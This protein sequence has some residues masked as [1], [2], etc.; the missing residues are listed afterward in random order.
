MQSRNVQT[1]FITRNKKMT[2]ESNVPVTAAVPKWQRVLIK[3]ELIYRFHHVVEEQSFLIRDCLNC[4]LKAVKIKA[5]SLVSNFNLLCSKLTYHS[6]R[7]LKLHPVWYNTVSVLDK[8]TGSTSLIV[9]RGLAWWRCTAL[10]K[11]MS[12]WVCGL[13]ERAERVRGRLEANKQ[14]QWVVPGVSLCLHNVWFVRQWCFICLQ[15]QQ[16]RCSSAHAVFIIVKIVIHQ[17]LM[18][19]PKPKMYYKLSIGLLFS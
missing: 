14:K 15:I 4:I 16:G 13:M 5:V 9:S 7:S 1:L 8:S 6:G 19:R 11:I 3:C 2:H 10:N 12:V 18:F 17:R